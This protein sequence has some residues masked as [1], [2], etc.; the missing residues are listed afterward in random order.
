MSSVQKIIKIFA[1]ILSVFIILNIVSAIMFGLSMFANIGIRNDKIEV[2][3]FSETYQNV[4]E[5]DIDAISS[6]IIIK[7]ADKFRVEAS[8]LK[9]QFSSKV[10]NGKL[11]VEERKRWIFANN[12][13]GEIIIYVPEKSPLNK[14][15]IDAGAGKIEIENIIADEF[16]LNQ[17]AG[18]VK[19]SNSG[20]NKTDIDGG[21][22]KIEIISSVLNDLKLDAGVGKIEVE[23]YIKGKSKIECGVGET[24]IT[25]LGEEK[26]YSIVAEKG[27]GSI[28]IEGKEQSSSTQYGIGE[29][30][31][32]I[33]GGIGSINLKFETRP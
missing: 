22:G 4:N 33:E 12:F 13:A 24:N 26:D 10:I 28:R 16:D 20:F 8:N 3:S 5:I 7:T 15:K 11:K 23:A 21:A 29:N 18:I 1:I 27:I 31:I 17:G 9:N 2:E 25:L 19:I 14:L 32:D 30:K 6:N